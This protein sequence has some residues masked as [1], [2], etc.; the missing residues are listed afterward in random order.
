MSRELQSVVLPFFTLCLTLILQFISL[1]LAF[2]GSPL[3]ESEDLMREAHRPQI[4]DFFKKHHPRL[5]D[6]ANKFKGT[7][8]LNGE[9]ILYTIN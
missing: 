2:D 5:S 3:F 7:V 9:S 1:F 6:N 8:V 4:T